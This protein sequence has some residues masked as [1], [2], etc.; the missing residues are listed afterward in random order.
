LKNKR[1][2]ASSV[3]IL[4]LITILAVADFTS[5][6]VDA[7]VNTYRSYPYVSVGMSTI[8]LGQ[9]ELIVMWTA[10]MP[11]DIGEALAMTDRAGWYNVQIIVTDPDG[12]NKTYTIEKTDSIGGGYV[13]FIPEKVG[14]H[15]VQVHFPAQWRNGTTTQYFYSEAWSAPVTFTV[16]EDPMP[17]WTESPLPSG[18]WSRPINQASRDW[19]VLGGNWLGG[20]H[21]YPSGAYGGTTSRWVD[22]IGPETAHILWSKPYYVG[23]YMEERF[24]EG[25]QTGHYQGMSWTAI[26]INGKLYYAPRDDA[27]STA[28]YNIV[29]L[30]TG[31]TLKFV[32]ETMPAFGQIYNYDS[33]NQHGGF[34]YLWQTSGVQLPETCSVVLATQ[35]LNGTVIRDSAA[36]TMNSSQITAGAVW[37]MLDAYTQQTVCYIANTTQTEYR[38]GGPVNAQG[39]PTGVTTGATGTAVYGLDGSILR[40]NIANLGS[41]DSP[42][43]YLQVWNTSAGTM[44]SSQTGTGYWQWRPS[45]GTFGGTDPYAASSAN[46][47]TVHDG[48]DFFSLNMSIP[49]TNN[50]N[51]ISNQTGTIQC[52]RDGE[53]III[54]YTGS[55]SEDGVVK[56]YMRCLSLEAGKVGQQLWDKYFTPPFASK[57]ANV[58][59]SLTGVF[60]D[61]KMVCFESTKLLKR[62]GV[63]LETGEQVWESPTEEQNNYYTMLDNYL[64]GKLFSFGYGG[65]IR[66]YDIKTGEILWNYNATNIGS[67]SPYGM[68]PINVFAVC[69]GKLYTLTGEH[70][71]SQP[72]YRGPNIRC[73]NATDGTEIW[74]ILGFGANGGAS[75]NGQYMQLA[76]GKVLGLNYFDNKIYCIGKGSSKTT[77]SAPQVVPELGSSVM[78]TGTVTDDTPGAGSRNTNDI[79]DM[80]LKGTPAICDEDMSRWMEYL[81]MN[82]IKP[83]DAKGVE[84]TLTTIDP[85]GNYIPI[86]DTRSDINGNYGIMFTPEVPGTYQIIATFDGSNAYGSSAATT[87]LGVAEE[88]ENAPTPTPQPQSV[89]DMYL[90]PA[91]IGIIV[92]IAIATVVIVLAVRK[93]P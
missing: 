87:Y 70:S 21:E 31:E 93:R 85:N 27:H 77:V 49:A 48:R 53:Y 3:A 15:S 67:E 51:S 89:A 23:G 61:D 5:Y 2:L 29:D 83:S 64:D 80:V 71:I 12:E 28:G 60:G 22:G 45:G 90:V 81:F 44:V 26:A 38:P 36:T 46:H 30:Y 6:P 88:A 43:Y 34:A 8:G 68:Y 4:A 39:R 66:A 65:Q 57:A 20:S 84:V 18:Y 32:N 11:V 9:N 62:W 10:D 54:G 17:F 33:G 78:L 16:Q 47:N 1:K 25:Y 14:V 52:V 24:T 86:G 63:S 76:D 58:S 82:Q 42:Q 55:N 41:V 40:Y 69:D 75:L 50:I 74:S 19:Y 73:I 91:T 72:I 59:I 56:G 35:Y 13:N 7:A 37:K 92:A 79:M